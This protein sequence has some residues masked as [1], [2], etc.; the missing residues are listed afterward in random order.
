MNKKS[1]NVVY[2]LGIKCFT[3]LMCQRLSLKKFSSIFGS[4]NIKN[5]QNIAKCFETDMDILLNRKYHLYTKDDKK[6]KTDN[7]RWGNRTLHYIFDDVNNYHSATIAHHDL[8]NNDHIDHFSRGMRR[9]QFIKKKSIPILFLIL[10]TNKEPVDASIKDER[11]LNSLIEFGF[12]NMHLAV[13][14]LNETIESDYK[15]YSDETYSIYNIKSSGYRD[16]KDNRAKKK[17]FLYDKKILKIL[18]YNFDF[19]NLLTIKDIDC[20]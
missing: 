17:E 18:N 1:I 19:S 10:S 8:S 9:L 6:F 5:P 13:F 3:E 12:T 7:K 11:L 20:E 15:I 14:N 4:L 2:S 16:I